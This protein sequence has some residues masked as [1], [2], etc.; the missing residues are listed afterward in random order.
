VKVKS[1]ITRHSWPAIRGL[2]G[3]IRLSLMKD[4]SVAL[5]LDSSHEPG[6]VR[7]TFISDFARSFATVRKN[8]SGFAEISDDLARRFRE[9][10]AVVEVANYNRSYP[11]P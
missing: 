4:L 6:P 10:G 2:S 9:A 8:N 7:K 5:L 1:V 11:F 3:T